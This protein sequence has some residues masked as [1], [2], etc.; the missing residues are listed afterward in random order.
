M[1]AE[2][3]AT[4]M[5]EDSGPLTPSTGT[6]AAVDASAEPSTPPPEFGP[7]E[8]PPRVEGVEL[9]GEPEDGEGQAE[10]RSSDLTDETPLALESG[11]VGSTPL[12]QRVGYLLPKDLMQ[13]ATDVREETAAIAA[14]VTEIEK[15]NPSAEPLGDTDLASAAAETKEPA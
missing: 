9:I 14:E 5:A 11:D 4:T 12:R 15:A 7:L 8:D 13:R 1:N 2:K 6:V 3:H 10:A